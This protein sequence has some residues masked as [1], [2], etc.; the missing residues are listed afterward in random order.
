M[1]IIIPT[2]EAGTRIQYQKA[3][4]L[5]THYIRLCVRF[6]GLQEGDVC[7]HRAT[8]MVVIQEADVTLGW[9][10]VQGRRLLD[11]E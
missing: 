7:P 6:W 11:A 2:L 4:I 8:M 3:N 5:R 10:W 9:R 1:G